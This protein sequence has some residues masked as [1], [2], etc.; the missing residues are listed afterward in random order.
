[1]DTRQ[2]D[3]EDTNLRPQHSQ[4]VERTGRNCAQT[5]TV[6]LW[7]GKGKGDVTFCEFPSDGSPWAFATL[8][9]KNKDNEKLL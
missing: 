9:T 6:V 8:R 3:D 4:C 7:W 1:M 2:R 5:K